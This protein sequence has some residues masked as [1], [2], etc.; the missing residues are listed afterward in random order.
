MT[1]Q[2]P[3]RELRNQSSKILERV[4]GGET[5]AVTNSGEVAAI[6]VPPSASPLEQLLLSGNIRPAVV[7]GVDFRLLP[8]SPGEET[9]G[10]LSD[11]RGDR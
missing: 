7:G 6:L 10:I 8:R 11:L 5:I 2:I 1:T 4:K 9:T 3:H